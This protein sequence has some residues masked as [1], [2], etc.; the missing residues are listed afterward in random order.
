MCVKCAWYTLKH[1]LLISIMSCSFCY[2]SAVSEQYQ[3]NVLQVTKF[4]SCL[5]F[6]LHPAAV[7]FTVQV[8][9]LLS[10]VHAP[11]VT[12]LLLPIWAWLALC[13]LETEWIDIAILLPYYE[14]CVCCRL[15]AALA[16]MRDT[17]WSA[18]NQNKLF[19][20]ASA[21]ASTSLFWLDAGPVTCVSHTLDVSS[22]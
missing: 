16:S 2:W 8:F 10:T 14:L 1:T 9:C 20:I 3:Q 7:C 21:Q 17:H 11:T 15:F 19:S 6:L 4:N 18:S 22:L 13:W 5:C 12:H